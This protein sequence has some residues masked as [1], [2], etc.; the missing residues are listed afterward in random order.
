MIRHY[1][2][3]NAR[4]LGQHLGGE[5]LRDIA[6]EYLRSTVRRSERTR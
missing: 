2:G 3:E 1:E 4:A 6:A 5:L